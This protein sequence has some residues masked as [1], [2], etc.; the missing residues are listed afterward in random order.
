MISRFASFASYLGKSIVFGLAI[1][2]ILLLLLPN[3]REQGSGGS[4]LISSQPAA[5]SFAEGVRRAAPAVVNVYTRSLRSVT[6]SQPAQLRPQGLGSGVLMSKKG[7]I[8]T[9]Y[10]VIADADQIIVALQDGRIFTAELIGSDIY[11]DLAVLYIESDD[12]PVIPQN[13]DTVAMVGDVVLA[14]GNPYN[15]GQTITQGIVSATGRSGMASTSY[16]DF[17]QTDA[18]INRGNS[19]GALVN[20]LG[21][22][23]GINTAAYYT[24]PNVESQGISFAIPY[25]LAHKIMNKL[26][27]DG[28]VIRGYLGIT[29]QQVNPVHAKQ[30]KLGTLTGVVIDNME[31]DGPA[32]RAGLLRN[33]VMIKMDDIAVAGVHDA[34]DRIAETRPGATVNITV[35]R[36]GER[37]NIP[38][39]VHEPPALARNN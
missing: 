8:L 34:M 36:R 11:T 2:A 30:L 4:L 20:S 15:L 13:R 29:G 22:L 16:Q 10:H 37:L 3:L 18:A 1:A 24:S 28:R 14:I 23:V 6:D 26:I 9:N 21:E 7:Y 27:S 32:A 12:L 17:L 35:V 5:I 38:V 33:D 31:P 25:A 39:Q 19:G